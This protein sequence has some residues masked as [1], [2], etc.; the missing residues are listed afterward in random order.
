[1]KVLVVDDSQE[2][3]TLL[4]AVLLRLGHQVEVFLS[5]KEAKQSS[6]FDIAIVDWNLSDGSGVDLIDFLS[7]KNSQA[8][9]VLISATRPDQNVLDRLKRLGAIYESKPL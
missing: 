5:V 3:L 9:L 7:K 6:D 2:L 4:K 1:M 8:K